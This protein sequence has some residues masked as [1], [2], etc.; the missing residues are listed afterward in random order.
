[1]AM[2]VRSV[3]GSSYGTAASTQGI[4][5]SDTAANL[6]AGEDYVSPAF[7]GNAAGTEQAQQGDVP[8]ALNTN[9]EEAGTQTA[10][11]AQQEA[12][13]KTLKA[14]VS[15]ANSKLFKATRTRCEFAYHDETKR[16]SIKVIDRDTDK[17]IREIPPEKTEELAEKMWE[18]AGILVD[19]KR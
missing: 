18:L 13:N 3:A 4:H 16:V 12:R 15:N 7:A 17:V 5:S 11:K 8:A 6:A 1:M 10:A 9:E 2:E 14:A 19:E